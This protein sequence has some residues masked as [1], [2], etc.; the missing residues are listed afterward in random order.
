MMAISSTVS[1]ANDFLLFFEKR[2][3]TVRNHNSVIDF[4][5]ELDFTDTLDQITIK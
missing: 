3:P 1:Y 2:K 4:L 5:L